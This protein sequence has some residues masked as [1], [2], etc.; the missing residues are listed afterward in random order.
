[1]GGFIGFIGEPN[2]QEEILTAMT[3]RL[4]H[5]GDL[6]REHYDNHAS[7]SIR[8]QRKI[9][10]TEL[11]LITNENKDL[12]L[13]CDGKIYNAGDLQKDLKRKG[14]R[15]LYEN[16]AEVIIHGYEEYG[17]ELLNKLNGAFAFIIWDKAKKRIFGARDRFGTKPLYYAKME[18]T[19]IFG[20]EIKGFFPHPS[21][22]KT[23][24]NDKLPEYLAFG[25]IPGRG[26]FFRDVFKLPAGHYLEYC[27]DETRVSNYF[28]PSF[29]I[30]KTK[31]INFFI[32][33]VS[34]VVTKKGQI[35]EYPEEMLEVDLNLCA[36]MDFSEKHTN[37]NLISTAKEFIEVTKKVQYSLDEP[38]S[39]P[40][41]NWLY[42]S[43]RN[44]SESN[45]SFVIN[46]G[47]DELF[48]GHRLYTAKTRT[49]G[50]Y[51]FFLPLLRKWIG[52]I[53]K[54][55]LHTKIYSSFLNSDK[56]IEKIYMGKNS[57]FMFDEYIDI[58]KWFHF[59]VEPLSYIQ[60]L[61]HNL[62]GHD[63]ITK[64]QIIDL[65][66]SLPHDLFI[67]DKA[68]MANAID[69]NLPFLD[70]ELFD[71][72]RTM[73]VDFRMDHMMAEIILHNTRK[74]DQ[75]KNIDNGKCFLDEWIRVQECYDLIASYFLS[76]TANQFFY[77][78]KIM[79]LLI[80]HKRKRKDYSRQIWAI[81]VFL[82]WYEQYF[83]QNR[84]N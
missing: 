11:N 37:R 76:E 41:A 1:M 27:A 20:S 55:L 25:Y 39:N 2:K 7:M 13:L 62:K 72:A 68:C 77:Q 22:K 83:G 6:H 59:A 78:D 33:A 34:D 29:E 82:I 24:N 3:E 65:S 32:N 10:D 51:K 28:I 17:R 8:A 15:F 16:D 44:A 63:D 74:N 64:M 45:K 54:Y 48:G 81:F 46:A 73:P 69:P 84:Y 26:T 42:I 35:G 31:D 66:L 43:S 38:S 57:P 49:P 58:V 23:F 70:Y 60:R 9:T 14:H 53:A 36:D 67:I 21:F 19:F 61:E 4:R 30:D 50:L 79:N 71:I 18:K 12:L 75:Q 47:K 80:K 40:L 5:R 52:L 56:P